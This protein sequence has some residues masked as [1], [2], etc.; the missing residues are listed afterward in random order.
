[1]REH[2]KEKTDENKGIYKKKVNKKKRG[3]KGGKCE[4]EEKFYSE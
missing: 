1:M 4:N 2:K 3:N